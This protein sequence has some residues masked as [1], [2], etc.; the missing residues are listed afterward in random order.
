MFVQKF[1]NITEFPQKFTEAIGT[2]GESLFGKLAWFDLL[3]KH[4]IKQNEEVVYYCVVNQQQTIEALFPLIKSSSSSPSGYTLKSLANFYSMEYEP[5][6]VK[7]ARKSKK[8]IATFVRY[9]ATEEKGWKS[10]DFFPL[11]EGKITNI[12]LKEE[13]AQYFNLT[14]SI[15]HKNWI[16][17]NDGEDYENYLSHSPTRIKDIRR[18]ERRTFRDHKVDFKIWTHE[19]NSDQYISDYNEV[20]NHSWK[21]KEQFSNFIPDLIRLCAR[22]NI[23]RLGILYVD[24]IPTAAQFNIFHNETT[25]IYKLSYHED[26]TNLSVGAILSHKMMNHAFDQDKSKVIDYG[27]GDD[28]YKKEWMNNCRNKM[29]L[30]T[31]NNS[32]SGKFLFFKRSWKDRIKQLF[33]T[34]KSPEI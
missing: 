14:S 20:Y 31:Y 25:L 23:L 16:Y 29:T 7:H 6:F 27:G 28:E 2:G 15:C 32:I 19:T 18:K 10:L 9:L 22:E 8:A 33:L 5:F 21:D 12:F 4:I 24:D 11:D 13:L 1:Y 26:Y 34:G 17:V 3:Q 30:T